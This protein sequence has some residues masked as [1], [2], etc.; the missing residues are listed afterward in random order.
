MAVLPVPVYPICIF[1]SGECEIVYGRHWQ[2]FHGHPGGNPRCR[3]PTRER[4]VLSSTMSGLGG[5]YRGCSGSP[6]VCVTQPA[7]PPVS[8]HLHNLGVLP[9]ASKAVYH[10]PVHAAYAGHPP[11][12]SLSRQVS[13]EN[14]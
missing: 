3:I 7:N 8:V 2:P 4:L 11:S 6:C 14:G 9:P 10:V 12:A 1:N 13:V 5:G